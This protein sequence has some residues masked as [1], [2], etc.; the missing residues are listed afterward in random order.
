MKTGKHDNSGN[1]THDMICSSCSSQST[2]QNVCRNNNWRTT[3][4]NEATIKWT[5]S[6]MHGAQAQKH[7][8]Y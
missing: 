3:E 2:C 4:D 8:D 5:H 7:L 1:L 6:H